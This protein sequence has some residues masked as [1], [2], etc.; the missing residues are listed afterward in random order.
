MKR[1]ILT[2]VFLITAGFISAQNVYTELFNTKYTAIVNEFNP[3]GTKLKVTPENI[4]QFREQYNR[5]QIGLDEIEQYKYGVLEVGKIFEAKDLKTIDKNGNIGELQNLMKKYASDMKAYIGQ[6][7]EYGI[8]QNECLMTYSNLKQSLEREDFKAA[9]DFWREL[10]KYYPLFQNA[11]SKGDVL[12]RTKIKMIHQDAYNAYLKYKEASDSKNVEDA[13]KYAMQQKKLLSEKELWIDTLLM[14]YDQRIKYFGNEENYGK[15]WSLGKKGNYM[16]EYRKDSAFVPA[17]SLLK[18][19]IEI[20]KEKSTYEVVNDFFD[21]SML[22]VRAGNITSEELILNY[23][24]SIDILKQSN[25]RY[26]ALIKKEK[27][28]S[29]PNESRVKNWESFISN[30]NTI[31]DRI[32]KFFASADETKCEYLIPTFKDKFEANKNNQDWLKNVTGILSFKEC[33]DDPFY[34]QAA[35]ALYKLD[36]SA[37]A[38]SKLALFY[39]KKE[40]YTEAGKY[41]KEAYTLEEDPKTKAEFYYYAAV[42]DFAQNK[43]ANARTLALKA[44]ELNNSYGKPYVLIA[45]IYAASAGQCGNTEFEKKAVYWA[46]VDKLLKAKSIDP[47][48]EEEA[49]DLIGKYTARFP[50]SE[51]G[52]ML[53]IYKG[54]TY[55]I[56]CWIQETTTVRY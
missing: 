36:P 4:D 25:E 16:M 45:K 3:S 49:N 29:S 28:K 5:L 20:E 9:C 56:E 31:S 6:N 12:M 52:F 30:N 35:E 32:T 46:A 48:V 54:S 11:Y 51:E 10:Y 53:S 21:A 14:I 23:N 2:S 41:F 55:K 13:N 7:N 50:G 47:S 34:G 40:N 38:A 33:T 42:V 19:S 24:L 1:I 17:Y 44:A 26:E 27:S 15:G 22:M 8:D 18:E 39:L 37:N 43:F